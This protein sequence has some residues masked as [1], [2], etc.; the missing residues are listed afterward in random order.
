[1]ANPVGN[2]SGGRR[3]ELRE[4]GKQFAHG[5]HQVPGPAALLGLGGHA[6]WQGG[7][8]SG[9]FVSGDVVKPA[10]VCH[11]GILYG[12]S[13][14]GFHTMVYQPGT[15]RTILFGGHSPGDVYFSDETWAYD[16]NTNTW[17]QLTPTTHP[18]GW[19]LHSMVYDEAADKMVLFG[20]I[21]GNWLKEDISDELW[22]F[23]P[24]LDEWSQLTP[25]T[26]SP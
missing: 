19:R 23:D 12:P 4:C 9:C 20:G 14:R 17:T 6:W 15:D 3:G 1:M 7:G 10:R 25:G 2:G 22:I 26:T 24:V 11:K 21:A 5:R 13:Y 18:S 16:Y 8:H